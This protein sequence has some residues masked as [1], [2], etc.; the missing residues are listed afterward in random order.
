MS[1]YRII[2]LSLFLF[3]FARAGEQKYEI[4]SYL[5]KIENAIDLK[6]YI[7]SRK[8]IVQTEGTHTVYWEGHSMTYAFSPSDD[9]IIVQGN[10]KL[11]DRDESEKIVIYTKLGKYFQ[12]E[13]KD[14]RYLHGYVRD[15]SKEP[16]EFLK[17]LGAVKYE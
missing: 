9:T 7:K 10:I 17:Q 8:P 16:S 5:G 11:T 3:Q 4:M 13:L 12:Y 1:V 14:G 2:I 15:L 6:S